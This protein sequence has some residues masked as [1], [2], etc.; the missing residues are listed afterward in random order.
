MTEDLPSTTTTLSYMSDALFQ[1]IDADSG[2]LYFE[3][4]FL[5]PC[6]LVGSARA[7]LYV[8]SDNAEDMDVFVQIRKADSTGKLLRNMNIPVGDRTNCKIPE[9]VDLINPLVYLGPTGCLRASY[10]ALDQKLTDK[11]WPEHD[12]SVRQP[13]H[14]GQVVEL[15]IGLWQTGI[16]YLPGE[17]LVFKVAGHNMTLAEFPNLRGEMPN[18]NKGRH[19]LHVGRSFPSRLIIPTVPV[20]I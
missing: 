15:E 18:Y 19:N 7:I 11:W 12:Y 2:E 8:S 9:P 3:Y 17:K 4:T 20:T 5:A 10:R 6:A 16:F 13:V 14:T 1:Q